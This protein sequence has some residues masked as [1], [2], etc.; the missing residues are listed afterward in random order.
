[1]NNTRTVGHCN[2]SV[3]GDIVT[4]FVLL[5]ANRLYKIKKRLI[6]FIFEFFALVFLKNFVSG[7]VFLCKTSQ[8]LV[9]QS[10]RHII[11]ISVRSFYL[12]VGFIRIYAERYVR[13]QCPWCS[14]PREKIGVFSYYLEA[15]NG[16]SFFYVLISLRHFVRRKGSTAARA[17]GNNFEALVKQT[18][19]IYLFESPPFGFDKIVVICDIRIVHIRPE[20]DGL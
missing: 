20:T 6:F 15:Y 1:M 10:F 9:K 16:A 8:Y 17:V 19:L 11:G 4:F 5:F 7:G 2:I 13:G 3:T 18:F 14:R 12:A